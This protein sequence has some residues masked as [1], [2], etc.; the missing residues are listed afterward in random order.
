MEEKKLTKE[1]IAKS[2][3]ER[4][5]YVRLINFLQKAYNISEEQMN[6]YINGTKPAFNKDTIDEYVKE[7]EELFTPKKEAVP[8]S[9]GK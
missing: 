3:I 9:N 2:L 8:V 1:S 4:E 6:L 7:L 5:W